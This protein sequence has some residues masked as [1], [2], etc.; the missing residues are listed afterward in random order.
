MSKHWFGS[1][2]LCA[3]AVTSAFAVEPLEESV[4]QR[5]DVDA[6]VALS[7]ENTDGS[8]RVYAAEQPEVRI[9]AIKKAYNAERLRGIVVDIK[10]TP[11]RI[12][13]TTTFPP[14]KNALSDRS[15]TVDYIIAV[16][17]TA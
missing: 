12:T 5:Y 15:G 3:L 1:S 16:P 13:I 4:E 2:A 8:I 11:N 17:P 14:R 6:N 7:V 10:A 9:Q